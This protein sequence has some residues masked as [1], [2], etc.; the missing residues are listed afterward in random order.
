MMSRPQHCSR[1]RAYRPL[2]VAAATA[3][4]LGGLATTAQAQ[5]TYEVDVDAVGPGAVVGQGTYA[6]GDTVTLEAT[7]EDGQV[8]TGWN[9]QDLRWVGARVAQFTMPEQDVSIETSFRPEMGSLRETYADYFDVGTIWASPASY[10]EGSA[11]SDNIERHHSVMTAENAMKPDALLRNDNIDP[12]TGDFTFTFDT[13]DDFVDQTLE[14]GMRVHGHVLVWHSQSPDRLN[15]GETGGTR[16]LARANMEHYIEGVLTHFSDRIETWDVV[17]E[18]F[19]DGLGSFDPETEDWRDYLRG[20]PNGGESDWY[21]AYA[22]GADTEA[23]ESAGDFIYDAFVF[24]RQYGPEAKL[25]YND[26]NDHQTAGKMSAIVAMATELNERYAAE[27]PQDDRALIESLGMQ[28]HHNLVH[29]P[30]FVCTDSA[31]AG[32]VDAHAEGHEAG[33]CSDTA[34]VEGAIRLATEAGFEVA[35][36][37]LDLMVWEAWNGQPEGTDVS[38]Y[39]DLGDPEVADRISRDDFTYWESRIDNRG[40][41]DAFQA[42]RFAE[43]FAVYQSFSQHIDRVT[44]W[45]LT[46][47]LSWRA[48]HNPLFLNEDFSEKLGAAAIDDPQ[49]WLGLT[50]PVTDKSLLRGALAQI[51]DL[52]PRDYHGRTWGALMSA[53]GEARAMANRPNATQA[54]VNAAN[55]RLREALDNLE[56]R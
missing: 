1:S 7:P 55:Q 38:L 20:G 17:N 23:G 54:Q 53:R 35:I 36:S 34:S 33:A 3:V 4:A 41:L 13:A 18:A 5:E 32:L 30:A 19:V 42:Q 31:F 8:W 6:P 12:E 22:E 43:Y 37:E 49:S 50:H 45:G 26:F 14:R 46:D 24:A 16:E 25:E 11:I 15:T 10:E 51:E 29:T 56:P 52:H 39:R 44:Y 2:V 27:F 47:R 9:S 40:E 48:T 21:D 28:S